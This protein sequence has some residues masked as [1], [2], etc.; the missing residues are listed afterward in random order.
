MAVPPLDKILGFVDLINQFRSVERVVLIKDSDRNEND[1]EHS[2]SLAMLAWYINNLSK[3]NLNTDKLL[4]YALVHDLVEVYAGDTF[5]Y[6][7]DADFVRSKQK[8]EGEAAH[9][10][11]KEYSNFS[12]L[13]KTIEQYE[14]R[15]DE[16]S[17]FIYALD[18]IAPMLNIYM[19]KGRTWK[20][21][22]VTLEM[23]KA[24]KTSKVALSPV[25][26]KIFKKLIERL[27]EEHDE[28]FGKNKK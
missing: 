3:L 9:K 28:L 18:K 20:E 16:E 25:I 15:E 26:E 11:K 12:E 5:L 21:T 19:D 8:R 6:H 2:Y 24:A 4:K 13:H 10:L 17:R 7:K 22:E 23:L 14:K 1:V 27:T